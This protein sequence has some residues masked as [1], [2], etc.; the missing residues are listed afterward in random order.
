MRTIMEIRCKY[1]GCSVVAMGIEAWKNHTAECKFN[2]GPCPFSG[3]SMR[4]SEVI[5]AT[6]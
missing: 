5:G 6:V 2:E 3:C 1:E 4:S